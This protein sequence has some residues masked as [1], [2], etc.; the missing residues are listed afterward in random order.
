MPFTYDYPRPAVTVDA[1]VLA[2][3]E[4]PTHVL[5]IQRKNEPFAGQW[6]FPGGFVDE[7]ENPDHAVA[8]ELEEET[9]LTGL[10]F[11][12]AG[13]Y[14]RP[15]RDPRGH[16]VSL[17]YLAKTNQDTQSPKAADDATAVQWHPLHNLPLLA[18]DHAEILTRTVTG[19]AG[20]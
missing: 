15:N 2:P 11:H 7:N 6:A 12:Q 4:N 3:E 19:S 14:G 9:H 16:T 17:V 1:I 20:L 5:L 18:F 13:F 10:T 8:R